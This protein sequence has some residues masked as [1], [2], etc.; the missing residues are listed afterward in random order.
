MTW[1]W[2]V[3]KCVTCCIYWQPTTVFIDYSLQVFLHTVLWGIILLHLYANC[4]HFRRFCV[5]Y[6]KRVPYM[7][8]YW[9]VWM[10]VQKCKQILRRLSAILYGQ[11]NCD[12]HCVDNISLMTSSLPCTLNSNNEFIATLIKSF[13]YHVIRW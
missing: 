2:D 11:L 5:F 1:K 6:I 3:C 4:T 8:D 12:C 9:L 10:M 13:P 7:C